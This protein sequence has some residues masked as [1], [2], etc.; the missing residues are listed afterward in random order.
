MVKWYGEFKPNSI[1]FSCV[2]IRKQQK[3][4]QYFMLSPF[5][6]VASLVYIAKFAEKE[7]GH[8]SRQ[9]T[10]IVFPAPIS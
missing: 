5:K 1:L 6:E 2:L 9:R 10:L 7:A 3:V 4:N 8:M